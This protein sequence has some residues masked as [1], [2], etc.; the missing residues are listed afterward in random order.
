MTRRSGP[1]DLLGHPVPG[2]LGLLGLLLGPEG[3]LVGI[4][5]AP[6]PPSLFHV[7]AFSMKSLRPNMFWFF[8]GHFRCE[9]FR[10]LVV[11]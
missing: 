4:V 8:F 7:L 3:G 11:S 10:R 6:P 5:C 2:L 1:L 9:S